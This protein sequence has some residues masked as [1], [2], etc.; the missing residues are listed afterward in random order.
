[1]SPRSTFPKVSNLLR[2]SSGANA[3]DAMGELSVMLASLKSIPEHIQAG[4]RC[5][6]AAP[7]LP[8]GHALATSQQTVGARRTNSAK[9]V[10]SMET[11]WRG[12]KSLSRPR[13][14]ET[15]GQSRKRYGHILPGTQ[16]QNCPKAMGPCCLSLTHNENH[17]EE[18]L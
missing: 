4:V 1:M 2:K 12:V 11:D 17:L 13:S 5:V 18:L 9:R 10:R 7:K 3:L 16:K 15:S 6:F 14:M 8:M